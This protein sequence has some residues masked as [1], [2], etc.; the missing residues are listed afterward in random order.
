MIQKTVYF[1]TQEDLD[2]FN[3]IKNKAEWLHE[4]LKREPVFVMQQDKFMQFSKARQ[5]GS[6]SMLCGHF[7]PKGKCLV[8]GCKYRKGKK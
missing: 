7:Q 1:R 3:A 5:T 6:Q 2:K 8:K 4:H